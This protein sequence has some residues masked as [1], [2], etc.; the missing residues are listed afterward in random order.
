MK[1]EKTIRLQL[2]Q[3]GRRLQAMNEMAAELEAVV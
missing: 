1:S 2:E 3:A